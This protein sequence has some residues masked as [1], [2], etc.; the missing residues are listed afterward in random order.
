MRYG[1]PQPPALN[2]DGLRSSDRARF[3]ILSSVRG[4]KFSWWR[5]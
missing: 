2:I 1:F 5:G 4:Q 3:F